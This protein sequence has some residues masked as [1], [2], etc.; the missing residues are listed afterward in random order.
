MNLFTK[1]KEINIHRKQNCGY[2][3]ERGGINQEFRINKYRLPYTKS[4]NK[5]NLQYREEVK[6]TTIQQL[7]E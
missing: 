4:M 7:P 2:L 3:G 5:K 1:Q 6:R